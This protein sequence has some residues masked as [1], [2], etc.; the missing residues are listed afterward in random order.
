MIPSAYLYSDN[1]NYFERH[2]NLEYDRHWNAYNETDIIASTYSY[3]QGSD[4]VIA[5][6][7]VVGQTYNSNT[8][9]LATLQVG[10][11]N[12]AGWHPL[13]TLG[14]LQFTPNDY[15][16]L[17]LTAYNDVVNSFPALL[18]RIVDPTYGGTVQ[19][20][21][22]PYFQFN[23]SC[24]R[25]HFTDHNNRNSTNDSIQITILPAWG[26]NIGY[27]IDKYTDSSPNS[28]NY[29]DPA[30]YRQN[31]LFLEFDGKLTNTWHY[32][33]M[34]AI[35]REYIQSL[36]NTPYASSPTRLLSA[37]VVG[38]INNNVILTLNYEHARASGSYSS[39]GGGTY[40]YQSVYAVLSFLL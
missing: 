18:N 38:P 3:T 2:Y 22:F 33:I 14:S 32:L 11:G 25:S 1:E 7:L 21:P 24:S 6:R 4:H 13:I 40:A 23:G 37:N 28:I 39:T 20:N 16:N 29:F 19:L 10:S 17:G 12:Y 9:T 26:G 15:I 31:T 8:T 36:D 27:S 34:G 35:G 5:P 30:T